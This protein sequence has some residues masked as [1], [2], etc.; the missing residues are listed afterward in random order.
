MQF[1]FLQRLHPQVQQNAL[2]LITDF[3]CKYRAR[4]PSAPN[5]RYQQASEDHPRWGAPRGPGRGRQEGGR[6][7]PR[8]LLGGGSQARGG[9]LEGTSNQASD[10]HR[11]LI[12]REGGMPVPFGDGW[13]AR[14]APGL[15]GRGFTPDSEVDKEP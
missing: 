4:A 5:G 8:G 3:L 2:Q 12:R 13:D 6:R 10:G 15:E 7:V 9:V 11:G 1:I 14:A